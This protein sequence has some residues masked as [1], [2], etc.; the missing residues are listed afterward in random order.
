MG[1]WESESDWSDPAEAVPARASSFPTVTAARRRRRRAWALLGLLLAIAIAVTS[2]SRFG[3]APP[4]VT[5]AVD[6]LGSAAL[7][8]GAS[9]IPAPAGTANP[10]SAAGSPAATL[11]S[12]PSASPSASASADS[13]ADVGTGARLDVTARCGCD[14]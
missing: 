2:W 6:T 5:A 14:P 11:A 8:M 4:N 3:S 12:T 7:T 13:L 9:S 1:N 10:W